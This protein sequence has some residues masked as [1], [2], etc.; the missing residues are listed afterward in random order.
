MMDED[1]PAVL[2]QLLRQLREAAAVY[3]AQL[4]LVV[5][6]DRRRDRFVA[7]VVG[8]HECVNVDE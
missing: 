5:A 2:A 1:H 4:G 7:A 3:P 8:P 6:L